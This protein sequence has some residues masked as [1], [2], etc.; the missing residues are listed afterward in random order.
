MEMI[1]SHLGVTQTQFFTF[2]NSVSEIIRFVIA[3]YRCLLRKFRGQNISS[4]MMC[5]ETK[6]FYG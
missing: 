5:F 6:A 3:E 2:E 1:Q 4:S